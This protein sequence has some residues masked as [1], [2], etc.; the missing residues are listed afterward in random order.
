VFAFAP[1]LQPPI[2]G[3]SQPLVGT[4]ADTRAGR[5]LAVGG[6]GYARLRTQS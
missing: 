5:T 2:W 3:A 6:M 1:A 4:I